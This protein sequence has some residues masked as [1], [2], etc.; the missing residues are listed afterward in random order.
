[1]TVERSAGDA[2]TA[3]PGDAPAREGWGWE[4]PRPAIVNAPSVP[5]GP[6]PHGANPWARPPYQV[7]PRVVPRAVALVMRSC[8]RLGPLEP[9]S[10]RWAAWVAAFGWLLLV[11]SVAFLSTNLSAVSALVTLQAAVYALGGWKLV[12]ATLPAFA[13]LCLAV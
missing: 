7:F 8:R 13:L 11:L 9:G 4:A 5:P 2:T 10:P 12:K 1:V 3:A 6:V